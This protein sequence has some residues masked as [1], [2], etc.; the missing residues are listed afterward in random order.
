ME[1]FLACGKFSLL[2]FG[3]VSISNPHLVR[4]KSKDKS[5]QEMYSNKKF[6][7]KCLKSMNLFKTGFS[8]TNLHLTMSLKLRFFLEEQ[9]YEKY[10]TETKGGANDFN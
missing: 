9:M 8:W 5:H 7:L 4:Q 10:S 2:I 1:K 6:A 3:I